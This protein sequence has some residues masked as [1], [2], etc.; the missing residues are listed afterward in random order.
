MTYPILKAQIDVIPYSLPYLQ[1]GVTT[2]AGLMTANG[3]AAPTRAAADYCALDKKQYATGYLH[4]V[5]M[6]RASQFA[7]TTS[8][9]TSALS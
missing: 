3:S 9:K 5:Q 2:T 8:L 4:A 6:R 7:A 1:P